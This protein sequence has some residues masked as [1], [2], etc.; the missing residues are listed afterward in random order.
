MPMPIPV[1]DLCSPANRR[2]V[3]DTL[4]LVA[5]P[6]FQD[7]GCRLAGQ[8]ILDQ[9][10][11]GVFIGVA[12]DLGDRRCDL[13]LLQGRKAQLRRNLPGALPRQNDVGFLM[14]AHA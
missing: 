11:T 14:Q 12:R 9:A 7:L 1:C 13:G 2:Q 4:A 8:G 10:A 5:D 6:D 3:G